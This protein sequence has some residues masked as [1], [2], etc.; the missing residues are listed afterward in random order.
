MLVNQSAL[1]LIRY[2]QEGVWHTTYNQQ[3]LLPEQLTQAWRC[4]REEMLAGHL[5]VATSLDSQAV[6]VAPFVLIGQDSTYWI[7]LWIPAI[8]Q[9]KQLAVR[10]DN[11]LP[12]IPGNQ[13]DS[14]NGPFI[15]ERSVVD[16]WLRF[17]YL[18]EDNQVAFQNWSDCIGACIDALNSFSESS[19]QQALAE[20]GFLLSQ[21]SLI[22]PESAITQLRLSPL[23]Q[24]FCDLEEVQKTEADE[25][26]DAALHLLC[27]AVSD[28]PLAQ[29]TYTT[30]LHML[31][32]PNEQLLALQAPIGSDKITCLLTLLASKLVQQTAMHQRAPKIALITPQSEPFAALFQIKPD[33]ALV[34]WELLHQAYEDY[35][36]NITLAHTFINEDENENLLA[37]LQQ[38]DESL[39]KIMQD[40]FSQQDTHQ[41]KTLLSKCLQVIYK[42]K[43]KKAAL[44]ALS[45]KIRQCKTKRTR[46]HQAIV[47]VVELISQKRNNEKNWHNWKNRFLLS[48]INDFQAVQLAAGKKLFAM[49]LTYWQQQKNQPDW[50]SINPKPEGDYDLVVIDSAHRF[51]PQQIMPYLACAKQ[52]LFVGDSKEIESLPAISSVAEEKALVKHHLHD[53]EIIEQMHYKGMLQSIGNAFTVAL[54]NT[55]ILLENLALSNDYHTQLSQFLGEKRAISSPKEPVFSEKNGF[56]F[57]DVRGFCS[58]NTQHQWSNELEATAIV[59]CL[60]TGALYQ[61]EVQIFAATVAQ[62]Q[63][64]L[65]KLHHAGLD[66]AVY[67]LRDSAP[68]QTDYVIF[69]PVYTIG[70]PR[71]FL[72]DRG[73]Q[74]FYR[75]IVRAKKGFWLIGD[76][77]IFDPKTHSPSGQLA[78]YLE[79]VCLNT[80]LEVS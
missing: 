61:S 30:L 53:E 19:W 44:L 38:E 13:F 24:Q 18:T 39:E 59:E 9:E 32:L 8:L 58:K 6:W 52:A 20:R 42:D 27:G 34:S 66:R 47:R 65:R 49:T 10:A 79:K 60:L 25:E 12:W 68:S 76:K 26:D 31:S 74:H 46:I 35:V 75:M 50:L 73:E 71:P 72:F 69:S 3:P 29:N 40:L 16:D 14:Q 37:K 55:N 2:W 17:E 22:L 64:I 57:L 77:R 43:N 28:T 48:D 36:K 56:H 23:L 45:D 63:L 62:Q 21:E 80:S 41:S 51:M 78:K 15:A 7:P 4:Q 5:Q 11:V 33:E 1:S 67:S 54:A 70:T